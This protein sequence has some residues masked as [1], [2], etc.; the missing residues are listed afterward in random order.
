LEDEESAEWEL[1]TGSSGLFGFFGLSSF[2]VERNEPDEPNQPNQPKK[3]N[4]RVMAT[5]RGKVGVMPQGMGTSPYNPKYLLLKMPYRFIRGCQL[6]ARSSISV[7][8]NWFPSLDL[9]RSRP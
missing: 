7:L 2:L 3:P 9:Q 5:S 1:R 8:C 4:K 6:H